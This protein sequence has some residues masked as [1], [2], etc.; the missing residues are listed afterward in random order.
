MGVP[1]ITLAGCVFI[2]RAGV[3]LLTNAGFPELIASD[4]EDYVAT[5]AALASDLPR[6]AAMRAG[7]RERMR[8]SPL[9]DAPRLVANLENLY[10]EAWRQWCASKTGAA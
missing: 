1:T 2:A 8:A 9:C 3:S 10:R 5:A 6:L 4:A 7:M